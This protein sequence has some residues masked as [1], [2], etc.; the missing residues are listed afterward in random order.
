MSVTTVSAVYVADVNRYVR[1]VDRATQATRGFQQAMPAAEQSTN[2][3]NAAQVGLAATVGGVVAIGFSKAMNLIRQYATQ[4]IQA[5]AQ[6]EQTVI[7]IEGI[8]T[9]TGMSMQAA[10]TKTKSY[11]ADLRRFAAETPF[12]LPQTLDAV[13]RLL[14]IGYTADDVKKRL[15]PTIGDIVSALGQPASAISGVV[16]AFGQMKSAG[17][18]LSQDLMQIGN[19]LPGF[20]AKMAIA[21]EM[22]GGNLDQ[23]NAAME[24]GTVESSVAIDALLRAMQKFPG[25]AGAMARQSQTLNG[26]MSTFKDTVNNALIDGL[27]P[28]IPS[29][30]GA[31][32]TL[33]GPVSDMATAFAQNLGPAVV[34]GVG[35]IEAIAPA[36]TA[37]IPPLMSLISQASTFTDVIVAL[38]PVIVLVGDALG[39][40]AEAVSA[41]PGPLIVAG[42][43]V[44]LFNR[45]MAATATQTGVTVG[46]RM[47][48]AFSTFGRSVQIQ[49]RAASIA[50]QA[51]AAQIA[52]GMSSV[53]ASTLVMNA[54]VA[55]ST[56]P[57]ATLR[58][59]G[60][61]ALR[62]VATAAS[63]LVGALG[64]AGIAVAALGA[65]LAVLSG[66]AANAKA[67]VDQLKD[68]VKGNNF[69]AAGIQYISSQ[70]RENIGPEEIRWLEKYKI[71]FSDVIDGV[72]RGGAAFD[73]LHA[74]LQGIEN[75]TWGM[76]NW[77][78]E[79]ILRTIEGMSENADKAKAVAAD[80]A[81]ATS[82][83]AR[84]TALAA[85]VS[86]EAQ[87]DQ[88]RATAHEAQVAYD[89]MSYAAR[90]AQSAHD[91]EVSAYAAT[92]DRRKSAASEGAQAVIDAGN[93]IITMFNRLK[94]ITSMRSARSGFAHALS[95]ITDALNK[96][97]KGTMKVGGAGYDALTQAMDAAVGVAE[98]MKPEK[99]AA[100]LA[101]AA[102]RIHAQFA[103]SGQVKV[104]AQGKIK[105]HLIGRA[106]VD[107]TG[108]MG[109]WVDAITP[110]LKATN[111]ATKMEA[112]LNDMGL[113]S[114]VKFTDGLLEALAKGEDPL[115]AAASELG[116]RAAA[117][118]ALHGYLTLNGKYPDNPANKPA[119]TYSA[120]PTPSSKAAGV[121]HNYYFG[122]LTVKDY[123]DGAAQAEKAARLRAGSGRY[124]SGPGGAAP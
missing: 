7:S 32:N 124:G 118:F 83:A 3:L 59:T 87:R 42:G 89:S 13:K 55:R 29:L 109:S 46:A 30:S 1:N 123:A 53:T 97:E 90:S 28:A 76:D 85:T 116:K 100:Y 34:G 4:G 54:A 45:I 20:N 82:D 60:V 68:S 93:K 26:V 41:I 111:K 43:A 64:P 84:A 106:G 99:R 95:G 17:R 62:G 79:T 16:Y 35:A 44:L 74:K 51:S 52:A 67:A 105:E 11:L 102:K 77:K 115:V 25:A 91:A 75:S 94:G 81:R 24:K 101:G 70:L 113:S 80:V 18:V 88:M 121:Q 120:A 56:G 108:Q 31:L 69:D 6:Y 50:T 65:A 61:V 119:L 117:A 58:A 63:G 5:A 21:N 114:G 72:A 22:F 104:P 71:N 12:E 9:G 23:M 78:A 19:A 8:F 92:E 96:G 15:L 107:V 48:G 39:V 38:Q 37:V 36:V 98:Q 10:A 112:D 27:M 49:M 103:K 33:V 122:D 40:L 14:S 2:R 110:A 57:F 47:A 73:T 86:G 66:Q